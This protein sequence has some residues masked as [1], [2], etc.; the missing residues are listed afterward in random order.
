MAVAA[1]SRMRRSVRDPDL[2]APVLARVAVLP[3]HQPGQGRQRHGG[4]LQAQEIQRRNIILLSKMSK[5][6]LQSFLCNF[7]LCKT[8]R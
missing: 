6:V 4:S 5:V 2:D 7:L 8:G 3:G 1:V